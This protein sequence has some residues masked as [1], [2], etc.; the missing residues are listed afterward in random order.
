MPLYH[1]RPRDTSLLFPRQLP[2]PLA[3]FK[4]LYSENVDD[5]GL[6]PFQFSLL[7]LL[8]LSLPPRKSSSVS[9]HLAG[10]ES[11]G[12]SS[13]LPLVVVVRKAR[14]QRAGWDWICT[15]WEGEACRNSSSTGVVV[16]MLIRGNVGSGS[17]GER[18]HRVR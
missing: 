16:V 1:L 2:L 7:L 3:I 4:I 5:S 17:I 18:R 14:G 13:W 10:W 12:R 8:L 11:R 15:S 9:L 6:Q